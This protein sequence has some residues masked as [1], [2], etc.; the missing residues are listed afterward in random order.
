MIG[1]KALCQIEQRLR[2]IRNKESLFGKASIVLLGDLH[3]CTPVGDPALF[4]DKEILSNQAERGRNIFQS[5][6]S[7]GK[8]IVLDK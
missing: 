2:E 7:Q 8:I 1:L 3:Q 5:F 6:L 4:S